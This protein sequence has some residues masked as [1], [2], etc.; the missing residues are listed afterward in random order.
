M[1]EAV[2][3]ER[4]ALGWLIL[5]YEIQREVWLRLPLSDIGKQLLVCKEVRDF[6]FNLRLPIP[7]T[8][9][10]TNSGRRSSQIHCGRNFINSN[11]Y[12]PNFFLRLMISTQAFRRAKR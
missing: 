9:P 2:G 3:W 12:C 6:N 11:Y 1:Q 4:G 5:P 8:S 7:R 10:G